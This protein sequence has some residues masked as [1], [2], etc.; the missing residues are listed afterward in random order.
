MSAPSKVLVGE[1][2]RSPL[3]MRSLC[4][5]VL[6]V[7]VS[8]LATPTIVAAREAVRDSSKAAALGPRASNSRDLAE[9]MDGL[10][11]RIDPRHAVRQSAALRADEVGDLRTRLAQIRAGIDAD[12]TDEAALLDRSGMPEEVRQ[13]QLQ[14]AAEVRARLGRFEHAL[15]ALGDEDQATRQAREADFIALLDEYA[16]LRLPDDMGQ[17][18]SFAQQPVKDL[19]REREAD[20][21]EAIPAGLRGSDD[22]D[23]PAYLASLAEVELTSAIRA[24]A[25]ELG[26]DPVAIYHFVRNAIEWQPSWGGQQSA[27]L[28]LA[29][30]RGNAQD[31]SALLIALL[32]ASDIPARYVLGSVDVPAD[33]FINWVGD[34]DT[35]QAAATFAASGGIPTTTVTSGGR[36]S[37]VRIEHVWVEAA[38][39]FHPSRGSVDGAPDRWLALDASYKQYEYL[40]GMNGAALSGVDFGG[41]V[42]AF[43]QSGTVNESEGWSQ[44]F[45]YAIVDAAQSQ[46][47]RTILARIEAMEA[48]VSGDVMRG[49]RSVVK[50]APVLPSALPYPALVRGASF[51]ELPDTLRVRVTLGLQPDYFGDFAHQATLPLYRLNQKNIAISFRPATAADAS[52][53]TALFPTSPGIGDP[54]LPGFLPNAIRVAP[55]IRMDGEVLL[56]GTALGLGAELTSGYRFRQGSRQWGANDEIVAGSYLALG[57][58][59]SNL[60]ETTFTTLKQRLTATRSIVAAGDQVALATLDRERVLGD[61][62]SAGILG[63]YAQYAGLADAQSLAARISHRLSPS[64]GTYGYEPYQRTFFGLVRGVESQGVFMNLRI[65]R[66]IGSANGSTAGIADF[67]RQA[68][69]LSSALEHM[70]PEQQFGGLNAVTEGYSFSAVRLIDRAL[71]QGQRLYSINRNNVG[72]LAGVQLD[73]FTRAEISSYVAAG[74]EVHVHAQPMTLGAWRGTGYYALDP[75]SG[76]GTYKISG[77]KNGGGNTDVGF[78]DFTFAV[79][80]QPGLLLP[81]CTGSFLEMTIN[82]FFATNE[83]IFGLFAPPLMTLLTAGAVASEV[84]GMTAITAIRLS[85]VNPTFLLGNILLALMTALI[86]FILVSIVWEIGLLIGSAVSAAFCRKGE[87]P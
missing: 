28:T 2:R 49:R 37:A 14:S 7:F 25:A 35:V 58:V 65:A 15:T 59:G 27:E 12:L 51:A 19:P 20:F 61:L 36:I 85:F 29:A 56:T 45:D 68:G 40:P 38:I 47:A 87:D 46:V 84:N 24:R 17:P 50:E 3:L 75:L 13:R 67:N 81:E 77:G 44:G 71:R 53:L 39:G 16:P 76:D 11:L 18:G 43:V 1:L 23:D 32:R 70:I 9:F 57:V 82:N 6:L 72:A 60:A 8:H 62:F 55:E 22:F 33:R 30:R 42:E 5:M 66:V 48:P 74:R 64:A 79:F 10:R 73:S 83:A 54:V 21:A 80:E 78:I 4:W 31:I 41:M 63:Y 52:A 69:I 34:F 86:N 26:H